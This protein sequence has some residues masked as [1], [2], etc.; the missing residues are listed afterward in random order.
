MLFKS[1]HSAISLWVLVLHVYDFLAG[2]KHLER[3]EE[4]MRFIFKS[5]S[6]VSQK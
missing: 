3:L 5:D 4:E 6:Q 2:Y 1:L